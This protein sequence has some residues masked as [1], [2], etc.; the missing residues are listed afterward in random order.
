MVKRL[1]V[2]SSLSSYPI[3]WIIEWILWLILPRSS[4]RVGILVDV[5]ILG[6]RILARTDRVNRLG[7][8]TPARNAI[9]LPTSS[10]DHSRPCRRCISLSSR[11]NCDHLELLPR[12]SCSNKLVLVG[13]VGVPSP[14]AGVNLGWLIQLSVF[15]PDQFIDGLVVPSTPV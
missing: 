14:Y 2:V 8:S 9:H 12:S 11:W 13:W 6:K 1:S 3:L 4:F 15:V 5:S 10:F 7:S